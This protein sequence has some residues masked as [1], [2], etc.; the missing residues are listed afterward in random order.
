MRG[1]RCNIPFLNAVGNREIFHRLV[2]AVQLATWEGLLGL[3]LWERPRAAGRAGEG[4]LQASG[5]RPPPELSLAERL[6]GFAA[7]MRNV[8]GPRGIA[9]T[10]R[11]TNQ[12]F[13]TD[14]PVTFYATNATSFRVYDARQTADA[15]G[16]V[17]MVLVYPD[18][19][20]AQP[21][22]GPMM[23]AVDLDFLSALD[24]GTTNL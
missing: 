14:A 13:L 16:R 19:A 21:T 1:S 2:D 12:G 8:H 6:A 3:S 22:P 20:H 10:N 5:S 11:F 4:W 23:H 24:N 15:N 7:G 18:V 9:R 17:L